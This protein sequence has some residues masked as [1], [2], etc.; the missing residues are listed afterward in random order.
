FGDGATSEGDFHE[1]MNF[2]GVFEVPVVFV[3]ENN[4]YAISVPREKQTASETLA[5]KAHAY[6]F[7]GVQVD[8][9]DVL[10]V[11][12]E[13]KN[14]VERA[15]GKHEPTLIEAVTYRQG[16]HT[17]SDDPTV[18][19]D[20][21]E[22]KEWEELDPIKRYESFLKRIGLWDEDY[23]ERVNEEAEKEA[24][25][26]AQDAVEELELDPQE[27]FEY[28]YSEPTSNLEEQ[29]RA[30]KESMEQEKDEE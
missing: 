12:R 16:P 11:Y 18:Y 15:R 10:A 6:G 25:E 24:K 1:G 26:A 27:M 29:R 8:G 5:Q 3:C 9:N 7:K 2:A 19:R 21:E 28:T 20:E 13:V 4:Q 14:A 17:T 30:L 22:E 23:A